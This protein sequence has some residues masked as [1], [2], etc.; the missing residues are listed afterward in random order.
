[1]QEWVFA[2]ILCSIIFT[3]GLGILIL[4]G[5]NIKE[6]SSIVVGFLWGNIVPILVW[7][8]RDRIKSGKLARKL[9]LGDPLLGFPSWIDKGRRYY[10]VRSQLPALDSILSI[11]NLK[12]IDILSISC[13]IITIEYIEK[14]REAINRG[15]EFNFLILD[16]NSQDKLN[17]QSKNYP[18]GKNLKQ[19]LQN[20]I[21]TLCNEKEK[22]PKRNIL[23][24]ILMMK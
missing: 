13:Y 12:R 15:V 7:G 16:P 18:T 3:V 17:L 4:V 1:M 9:R 20:T 22:L 23:L 14:I 2:V 21:T 8:F 19:Q 24:S 10:R 6:I 5:S 11:K